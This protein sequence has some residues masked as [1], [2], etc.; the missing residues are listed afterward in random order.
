MSFVPVRQ[1]TG[2]LQGWYETGVCGQEV[3]LL[4]VCG[5]RHG[6]EW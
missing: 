6:Q 2:E 5:Y 1:D 4:C 3:P